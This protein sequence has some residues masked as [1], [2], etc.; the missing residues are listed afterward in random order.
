MNA[1]TANMTLTSRGIRIGIATVPRQHIAPTGDEIK[2][3]AALLAKPRNP[4][5]YVGITLALCGLAVAVMAFAG[6]LPG[7][8]A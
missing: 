4:E 5:M 8:G 2:L 7:G 1:R 3:Q 6:W